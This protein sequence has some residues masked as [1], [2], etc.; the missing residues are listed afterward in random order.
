MN[1]ALAT[2]V[3]D[4][5]EGVD[6]LIRRIADVESPEIRKMR[7]KVYVALVAAK[8]A[9]GVDADKVTARATKDLG[10]FVA[11]ALEFPAAPLGFAL[12]LALGLGLVVAPRDA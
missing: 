5:F 2:T 7:A 1:T 4:L 3:A 12:L 11:D 9:F 10:R 8:G 6:D